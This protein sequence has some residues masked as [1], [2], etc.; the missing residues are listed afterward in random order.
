MNRKREENKVIESGEAF[1][2]DDD[3]DEIMARRHNVK[4]VELFTVGARAQQL[5]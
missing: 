5:E 2:Y 1:D 3:V 4:I